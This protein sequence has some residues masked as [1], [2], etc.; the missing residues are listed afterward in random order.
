MLKLISAIVIVSAKLLSD[1]LP[2]ELFMA[3]S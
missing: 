3:L 1:I 2:H